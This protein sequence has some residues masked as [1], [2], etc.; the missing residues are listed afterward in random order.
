[1]VLSCSF[2]PYQSDENYLE[3]KKL[4][5]ERLIFVFWFKNKFYPYFNHLMYS[6]MSVFG[7]VKLNIIHIPP[8]NKQRPSIDFVT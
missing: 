7:Y 4:K 6:I 8:L 1:M 3:R 5:L 2:L